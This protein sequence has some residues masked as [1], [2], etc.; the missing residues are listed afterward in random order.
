MFVLIIFL[1]NKLFFIVIA[2]HNEQTYTEKNSSTSL[3]FFLFL[4][5]PHT[6]CDPQLMFEQTLQSI[7][8]RVTIPYW[9]Y[10]I[11]VTNYELSGE[12]SSF[13]DSVVFGEEYFGTAV[14]NIASGD[15]DMVT[16]GKCAHSLYICA[17]T[18]VYF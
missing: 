15:D 7:N 8:P 17:H 2:A 11:D 18:Y 13:F 9:D 1:L 10:T 4:F 16:D 3:S 12:L 5:F 6:H 14:T